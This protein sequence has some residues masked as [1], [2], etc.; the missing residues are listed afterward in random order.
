M[1]NPA[2]T[3]FY[4]RERFAYGEARDRHVSAKH[5]P[6][7]IGTM[8]VPQI[9]DRRTD[10]H[11]SYAADY[12]I[13]RVL[14]GTYDIVYDGVG[15]GPYGITVTADIAV[16]AEVTFSGLAGVNF[17]S[18]D[19]GPHRST[20]MF[21]WYGYAAAGAWVNGGFRITPDTVTVL[22]PGWKAAVAYTNL[23]DRYAFQPGPGKQKVSVGH[24]FVPVS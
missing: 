9:S 24:R 6:F 22:A 13:Y 4:C 16:E 21:G 7:V 19:A 20:R 8:T 14:P 11:T 3:C 17:A 15:Y 23:H 18:R 5:G 12:R 2:L 1:S 10:H